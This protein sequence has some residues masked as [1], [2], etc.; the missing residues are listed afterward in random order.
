MVQ[1]LK[2]INASKAYTFKEPLTESTIPG[3]NMKENWQELAKKDIP[4]ISKKMNDWEYSG[5]TNLIESLRF[6]Y[7]VLTDR[8]SLPGVKVDDSVKLAIKEKL[9]E[10]AGDCTPGFHNRVNSLYSL[11]FV[12]KTLP[13]IL[14]RA[15]QGLAYAYASKKCGELAETNEKVKEHNVHAVNSIMV[16]AKRLGYGVQP[17][18]EN[19]EYENYCFCPSGYHFTSAYGIAQAQKKAQQ[20]AHQAFAESFTPCNILL[21]LKEEI[22]SVMSESYAYRGRL[23]S[24]GY[25]GDEYN[26]FKKFLSELLAEEFTEQEL[27]V[28]DEDYINIIDV[29]WPLILKH[30]WQKLGKNI[31]TFSPYMQQA[32]E[33]LIELDIDDDFDEKIFERIKPVLQLVSKQQEFENLLEFIEHIPLSYQIKLFEEYLKTL[34]R[35]TLNSTIYSFLEKNKAKPEYYQALKQ[36]VQEKFPNLQTE[37]ISEITSNNFYR[38]QKHG[39][40]AYFTEPDLDIKR[41]ISKLTILKPKALRDMLMSVDY[42]S[43][44]TLLQKIL[45]CKKQQDKYYS[46]KDKRT[47]R[48]RFYQIP[49]LLNL[50]QE[51]S[52]SEIDE[53]FFSNDVFSIVLNHDAFECIPALFSLLAK[54][55][56]HVQV[57]QIEQV[58]YRVLNSQK[59]ALLYEDDQKLFFESLF[60]ILENMAPQQRTDLLF[61]IFD[62]KSDFLNKFINRLYK[63][64]QAAKEQATN[65]E[66]VAQIAK[67][68]KASFIKLIEL[69]PV[70]SLE[71]QIEYCLNLNQPTEFN[72]I[73]DLLNLVPKAQQKFI[74]A[75]EITLKTGFLSSKTKPIC[76]FLARQPKLL[77]DFINI[78]KALPEEDRVE[79]AVLILGRSDNA[80][81]NLLSLYENNDVMPL[82]PMLLKGQPGFLQRTL[83]VNLIPNLNLKSP[84]HLKLFF[85]LLTVLPIELKIDMMN[86]EVRLGMLGGS[87]TFSKLLLSN[88]K[89]H[90]DLVNFLRKLNVH[91]RALFLEQ[92][93]KVDSDFLKNLLSQ[94]EVLNESIGLVSMFSNTTKLALIQKSLAHLSV[95]TERLGYYIELART[96]TKGELVQFLLLECNG[97]TMLQHIIE[98]KPQVAYQ[99]RRWLESLQ[100][101]AVNTDDL[102]AQA[103]TGSI[104]FTN[105]LQLVDD[106]LEKDNFDELLKL[107]ADF[108]EQAK[109]NAIMGYVRD[110]QSEEHVEH[111]INML[112][113]L[114]ASSVKKFFS[115]ELSD[116]G[117]VL[118]EKIA[119]NHPQKLIPIINYLETLSDDA[120]YELVLSK[121]Y[122][123]KYSLLRFLQENHPAAFFKLCAV[124]D[125]RADSELKSTC[126]TMLK[127]SS[128][129]LLNIALNDP[130]LDFDGVVAF[131]KNQ[132]LGELVKHISAIADESLAVAKLKILMPHLKKLSNFDELLLQKNQ[133]GLSL[134]AILLSKSASLFDFVFT[135]LDTLDNHAKI[136]WLS[137]KINGSS[138]YQYTRQKYPEHVG[139]VV[140][141]IM[142]L[143]T[144]NWDQLTEFDP[145]FLFYGLNTFKQNPQP[146]KDYLL[147]TPKQHLERIFSRYGQQPNLLIKQIVKHGPDNEWL[148]N[149]LD[150]LL[151]VPVQQ[152]IIQSIILADEQVLFE[153]EILAK[154]MHLLS[155]LPTVEQ[156]SLLSQA[157]ANIEAIVDSRVINVLSLKL[158]L[159][160]LEAKAL[161][162]S[163]PQA[164]YV[165]MQLSDKLNQAYLALLPKAINKELQ[166]EPP[167]EITALKSLLND[168]QTSAVLE[169]HR[170]IKKVVLNVLGFFAGLGVFYLA[171]CLVNLYQTGGKH[172]FFHPQ[173]QSSA[174]VD[175]I[176][177]CLDE[178][179]KPIISA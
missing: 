9:I 10:G 156:G 143:P 80:L 126:F 29:N 117:H 24:G 115:P 20:Y 36:M 152:T 55:S 5:H 68:D 120:F 164:Q 176:K 57:E 65:K 88:T 31:F 163:E 14:Q 1:Q 151:V 74:L 155:H 123:Q 121:S 15:R 22:K 96:F 168:K 141:F 128:E 104:D 32:L 82:L 136:A 53:L 179:E 77:N 43:S 137:E 46:K 3:F 58:L 138:I 173:T 125:K 167:Q 177:Q 50:I 87:M 54:S 72:K 105:A 86:I 89:T 71:E 154:T 45:S 162:V 13:E 94:D 66:K 62:G 26:T 110:Y 2:Y 157:K 93:L 76:Y 134:A 113:K 102:I 37:I 85:E 64:E 69:I 127:S 150:K 6:F 48:N 40:L 139:R 98:K 175:D 4:A 169:Q 49:A 108:P 133:Q 44:E 99:V 129:K 100:S 109:M 132:E 119:S 70:V 90:K 23:E 81:T 174:L 63:E 7:A 103:V 30:V 131:Y 171:G 28:F 118:I 145:N 75:K 59:L 146:V 52:K 135:G 101:D 97:N 83:T 142:G 153:P 38:Y 61:K 159:L 60:S 67:T 8:V 112:K 17:E 148:N 19:D 12:P 56:E 79:L 130:A 21:K 16:Q 161:K 172:F 91:D 95:T 166:A 114:S 11:F 147:V 34:D 107:I 106:D 158:Q 160:A 122:P 170:G 25:V 42:D 124:L 92:T 27:L 18:Q 73:E 41:L 140:N 116:Y 33:T 111:I 149:L 47:L 165:I 84:L 39:L 178:V 144:E 35:Y 51:F 78:Y